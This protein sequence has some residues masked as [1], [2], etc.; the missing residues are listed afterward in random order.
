MK[1]VL[2]FLGDSKFGT[3]T[4]DHRIYHRLNEPWSK[5]DKGRGIEGCYRT[6]LPGLLDFVEGV[7]AIAHIGWQLVNYAGQF[8]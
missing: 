6:F 3:D 5:L 1:V 2:C 8:L 4:R 7:L